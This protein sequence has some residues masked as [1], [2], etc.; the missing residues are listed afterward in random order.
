[1]KTNKRIRR[2]A[3]LFLLLVMVVSIAS[4]TVFA[5]TYYPKYEGKTVSIVDALYAVGAP[6]YEATY[7][8][9]KQIAAANGIAD[10][11]GTAAQNIQMLNMLKAGTLQKPAD[12]TTPA[13]PSTPA[14][15]D[16]CFPAYTGK[17]TGLVT[18]LN[19]VGATS[20]FAYRAQIALA[21]GIVK[22][23]KDYK[24]T[25]KQNADMIDLLVKG[26]LRKPA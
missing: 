11:R 1:M 16:G 8:F 7:A 22:D 9:R 21:N 19:A 26:D 6:D 3:S 20:T 5:A 10:Y 2:A 14:T 12:T 4:T 17:I 13:A 15:K 24:G 25:Y 23:I 18:S